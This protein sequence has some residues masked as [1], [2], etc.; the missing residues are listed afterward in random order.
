MF[1]ITFLLQSVSWLSSCGMV[2][3][4]WKYGIGRSSACRALSHLALV[5]DCHLGQCRFRQELY[6]FWIFPQEWQTSVWPPKKAVRQTT[7][8]CMILWCSKGMLR[9]SMYCFP[10]LQKTSA[11][12]GRCCFFIR[13]RLRIVAMM[14]LHALR[15]RYVKGTSNTLDTIIG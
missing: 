5:S 8:S 12:S 13:N 3:T 9:D 6:E 7:I 4:L 15:G 11:N 1:N 14:S 2:N 10:Y